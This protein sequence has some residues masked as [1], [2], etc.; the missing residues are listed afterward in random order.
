MRK[1]TET[2]IENM[3]HE[4]RGVSR[5]NGKTTFIHNALNGETV[6]CYPT[7]KHRSFN[8]AHAENI[9]I[10]STERSEPP[11][12]HYQFCGGCNLQH[13]QH[14]YQI[15]HKQKQLAEQ[16]QHL[17]Q[18]A[19]KQWLAPL[20]GPLWQYRH[21]ARLGVRHVPGKTDV[22][23]GFRERNGR[24][25]TDMRSCHIL[26][27]SV[28]E[29]IDSLRQL[30]AQLSIYQHIAQIEVAVGDHRTALIFRHLEAFSPDD[31]DQLK[32]YA[33]DK[34]MDIYLQPGKPDSIHKLY[35]D[36]QLERLS[37]SLADHQVTLY[38]HPTDFT[39]VNP[40]IN[41]KM[42]QQALQLLDI[43]TDDHLLD[44]FCGIGNF[45][46]PLA[47]YAKHVTAVE[48]SDEMVKRGQENA[49][50]NNID[51]INFYSADLTKALDHHSWAKQHYD[52]IL[53]DPPR[54]G[55]LELVSNIQRFDAQRIVYVSCHPASLARDTA[56]LI[57][58]G[59]QLEKAGIMD[60]FPHTSHV[61]SI[62]L[63]R[64]L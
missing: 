9:L 40:A 11:C 23:V 2:T 57:E 27:P 58:Q 39:Q 56:S 64:K 22:L 55:A 20:T 21:K 52:A 49:R 5:I 35:P 4:G 19:P 61:E 42:I 15:T 25:L 28:G 41:Q 1:L 54:S 26:H 36:D 7:R 63:F 8:E 3:S 29:N 6:Q 43:Q 47:R 38:F 46:L 62:A 59:Y 18:T 51:N 32:A 17:G 37:M 31:L 24:Y 34:A 10:A 44:L 33:K 14:P 50:A 45:S 16:L 48:G 53:L 60:M 13:W 30:I 12:P